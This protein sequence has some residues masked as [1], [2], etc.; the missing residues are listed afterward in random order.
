MTRWRGK[1]FLTITTPL[2]VTAA[3]SVFFTISS[4]ELNKNEIGVKKI[5]D[6]H[7]PCNEQVAADGHRNRF[8]QGDAAELN[9][10][11]YGAN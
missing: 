7:P 6:A 9:R 2:S 1:D 10:Y 4:N 11:E 5:M 3:R 8:A